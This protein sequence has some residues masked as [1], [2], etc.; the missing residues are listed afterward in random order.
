MNL[1]RLQ[2]EV[3]DRGAWSAAV[4]GVTKSQTWLIEWTRTTWARHKQDI[5][6]NRKICKTKPVPTN[7]NNRIPPR[8]YFNLLSPSIISMK[9]LATISVIHLEPREVQATAFE[10]MEGC[11]MARSGP[12]KHSG[13]SRRRLR[14]QP[15]RWRLSQPALRHP[16]HLRLRRR[17]RVRQSRQLRF[18]DKGL[19]FKV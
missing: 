10:A 14:L 7:S 4:H 1:S 13:M 8:H 18:R 12:L 3:V 2:E 6:M 19:W 9:G 15:I 5:R 17:L 11:W 16:G